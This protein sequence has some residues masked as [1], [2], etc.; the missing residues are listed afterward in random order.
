M[1][2]KNVLLATAFLLVGSLTADAATTSGAITNAETWSGTVL[3]KGDVTVTPS[4]SL[5]I[6]PGT[7][8]ECDP[9][10]D[11]QIGGLHTSRIELIVNEGTL[12]AV[13]TAV[14]PITFT[15]GILSTNPPQPGDWY[16]IRLNTTNATLRQCIVEYGK[17]SLR[18]EGGS[19]VLESCTFRASEGSGV[20]FT[21]SGSLTDCLMAENGT[22][23]T[24]GAGTFVLTGCTL[25]NNSG[26]GIRLDSSTVTMLATKVVGNAGSGLEGPGGTV[27]LG[28]D[29][30][31]GATNLMA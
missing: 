26:S 19:A 31:V 28:Q 9:R 10:G 11:D 23:V 22:G 3:L 20:S 17:E 25:T 4:G 30:E 21:V 27:V 1:R 18:V 16:G 5:T 7:R 6:L 12:T 8:V 24:V 2:T 14:S 29:S 13:G 15:A